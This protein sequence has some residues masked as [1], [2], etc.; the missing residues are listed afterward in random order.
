MFAERPPVGVVLGGGRGTR[1]GGDK[2][3]VS[4]R[5][6][7]LIEY[8]LRAQRA[9]LAD[10]A[11]IAKPDTQLPPLEG[12][13]IWLEP[14]E[15]RHPLVGVVEALALAGGRPVIVCAADLPFVTPSLIARIVD[16]DPGRAPAVIVRCAGHDQPLLG[17]YQP[18]AAELLAPAA[19]GERPVRAAVAALD[20]VYLE[21]EDPNELF[22]V[23]SPEDLLVAQAMLDRHY[24]NVKS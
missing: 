6:L 23:N 22:N 19:H 15:P 1:M 14:A 11:V 13:V 7:P 16:A 8:P 21:V 17:C 2:L 24:P 10:L 5:G 18:A 4:L 12:V 20:P 3:T 9:V